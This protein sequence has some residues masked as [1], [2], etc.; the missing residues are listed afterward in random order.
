[1]KPPR[2]VEG[3]PERSQS[4]EAGTCTDFA[5]QNSVTYSV[6]GVSL[7]SR[8]VTFH[9]FCVEAVVFVLYDSRIGT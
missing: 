5:K 9:V 6:M 7:L 2:P 8:N 3:A 4:E 1:M